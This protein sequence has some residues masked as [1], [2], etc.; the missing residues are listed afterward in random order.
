VDFFKRLLS[1]NGGKG[2]A[3][4]ANKRLI[5]IL[6]HDRTDI[7]PQLLENLR[8]EMIAVLKKY[9][10]I[11]ESNI[12][13][14]LDHAGRAAALVV[15]VPIL[16]IRRG[17]TPIPDADLDLDLEVDVEAD[18]DVD[19]EETDSSPDSLPSVPAEPAGTQNANE[20]R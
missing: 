12:E 6:I 1:A 18:V 16:R 19:V 7:S 20:S 2:S 9:M 4:E 8:E 5:S 3:Q 14:D 17:N 11:D 10:E 13:M 15:N